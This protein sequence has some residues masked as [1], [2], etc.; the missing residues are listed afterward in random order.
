MLH[1]KSRAARRGPMDEMRQL[2]RSCLKH[3]FSHADRLSK[4]RELQAPTQWNMCCAF[5]SD[6]H[7]GSIVCLTTAA[8]MT[9]CHLTQLLRCCCQQVAT[10]TLRSNCRVDE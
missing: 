10:L 8:A 3:S 1:P 9:I 4:A 6:H 7:F 5:V 2:V